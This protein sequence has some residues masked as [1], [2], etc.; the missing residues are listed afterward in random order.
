MSDLPRKRMKSVDGDRVFLDR[1]KAA[2]EQ[3]HVFDQR[4]ID[5]INALE[6]ELEKLSDDQLKRMETHYR[7][8]H[9]PPE[10]QPAPHEFGAERHPKGGY[11]F[12]NTHQ[13]RAYRAALS[14]W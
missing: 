4:E 14:H 12:A 6:P 9:H 13:E 1:P 11:R 7:W 5:A 8:L 10:G 3:V 2:P